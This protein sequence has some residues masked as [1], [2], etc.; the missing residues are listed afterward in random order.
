M[1]LTKLDLSSEQINK[2]GLY[3]LHHFTKNNFEI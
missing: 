2:I 3:V 1:K